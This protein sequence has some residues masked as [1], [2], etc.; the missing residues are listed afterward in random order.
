MRPVTDP[1]AFPVNRRFINLTGRRFGALSVVSFAG[2]RG[3][4]RESCWLCRCDCGAMTIVSAHSLKRGHTKSCGSTV[5]KQQGATHPDHPEHYLYLVW[6][7]MKERCLDP[8]TES[9]PLYGGRGITVCPE[10]LDDFGRFAKD[11]GPRPTP[12]HSIDRWP[13]N[14][15]PYSPENT[16]WATAKE[17]ASN[18][19]KRGPT[20]RPSTQIEQSCEICKKAFSTYPSAPRKYCSRKCQFISQRQQ[21][22]VTCLECGVAFTSDPSRVRKFCCR[23]CFDRSKSQPTELACAVCGRRLRSVPSRVRKFCSRECFDHRNYSKY[24]TQPQ[25]VS[26]RL[27]EISKR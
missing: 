4:M 1:T 7:G 24:P 21:I 20:K 3:K 11:M 13:D 26:E 9:F 6:Y 12:K 22:A 5:H 14:D 19:R 8:T 16:R 23:A 10:W 15:G 27:G 2:R 25:S 17:Q 18:R